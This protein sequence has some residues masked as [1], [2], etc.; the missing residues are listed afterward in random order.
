MTTIDS[1]IFNMSS[2]LSQCDS[3]FETK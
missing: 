2:W 3:V 1:A